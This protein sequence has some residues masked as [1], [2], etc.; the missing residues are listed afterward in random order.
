[1][2]TQTGKDEE[3]LSLFSFAIEEVADLKNNFTAHSSG[4]EGNICI[5]LLLHTPFNK[6][7]SN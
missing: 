7:W 5:M 3:K 6:L 2:H 4:K 1:M